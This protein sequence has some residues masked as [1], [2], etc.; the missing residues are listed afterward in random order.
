[1]MIA[2]G[3]ALAAAC[4][5]PA[6]GEAPAGVEAADE[7]ERPASLMQ[8]SDLLSRAMPQPS[9]SIEIG[10]DPEIGVVDV[11]LPEGAGPHPT[12]LM[13]HGGCWQK[14]IADRTLMNYAAEALRIE[15]FA[16]WNVEYRGVDEEGGGYP[17][18]F[19]DVANA[20][21]ALARHGAALGLDTRRV[22]AFGHAA[23]GH[24]AVWTAARANLPEASPL[25]AAEPLMLA[26]VINSGGLADLETSA[27]VTA[28]TCLAN[29]LDTLT[30]AP[31]EERPNVFSDTSPA[32]FLP[33][34]TRIISV[35]GALDRIAP[36]DLGR[37]L[38]EKIKA[39]GGLADYVNVPASGHVEL[40]AP[41][42]LAFDMQVAALKQLL[43][44]PAAASD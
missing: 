25:F 29:I 33:L 5:T 8:W 20:A 31:S 14:A 9:R 10:P 28:P 7:T 23:G 6:P 13:I 40:V 18:T 36:P 15:G 27:P 11:W 19:L 22:A 35:N 41:G 32:E 38:T 34:D 2:A 12:V 44:D 39:A 16:V 26:G 1:M 17:G 43:G 4:T 37:G 42:T 21:D 3:A 30:G 24:L